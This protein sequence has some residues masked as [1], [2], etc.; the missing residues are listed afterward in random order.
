MRTRRIILLLRILLATALP[1]GAAEPQLQQFATSHLTIV[2]ADGP[3]R[4]MSNLPRRRGK[5]SRG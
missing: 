4:F 1:G 3:H 5:W 2:S